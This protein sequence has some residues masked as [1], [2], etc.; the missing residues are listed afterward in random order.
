MYHEKGHLVQLKS[1]FGLSKNRPRPSKRKAP[2]DELPSERR[3]VTGCWLTSATGLGFESPKT[4]RVLGAE[5]HPIPTLVPNLGERFVGLLPVWE[6]KGN[7]M[8]CS[9]QVRSWHGQPEGTGWVPITSLSRET[10]QPAEGHRSD[11]ISSWLLGC[12]LQEKLKASNGILT[13]DTPEQCNL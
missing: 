7:H 8:T 2:P 5:C 10:F 11:G 1:C 6:R 9:T 13:M 4:A 12:G 3:S